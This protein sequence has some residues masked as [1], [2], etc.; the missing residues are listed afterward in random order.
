M[1]FEK[2]IFLKNAFKAADVGGKG[3]LTEAEV[4]NGLAAAGYQ[5]TDAAKALVLGARGGADGRI[6]YN[7]FVMNL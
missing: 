2:K 4:L 3:Y 7:E 6:S 1:I 5:V